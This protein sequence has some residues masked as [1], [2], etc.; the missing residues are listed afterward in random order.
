MTVK[1]NGRC[2]S[3][4]ERERYIYIYVC[5][6]VYESKIYMKNLVTIFKKF[7]VIRQVKR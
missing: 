7:Y 5:M 1:E 6:Y 3:T 2:N 4:K